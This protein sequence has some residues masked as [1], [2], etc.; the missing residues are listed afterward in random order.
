MISAGIHPHFQGP[1]LRPSPSTFKAFPLVIR[2][3]LLGAGLCEILTLSSRP[4]PSLFLSPP[5]TPPFFSLSLILS[6]LFRAKPSPGTVWMGSCLP[7]KPKNLSQAS[8]I[9]QNLNCCR[10]SRQ[11]VLLGAVGTR[12]TGEGPAWAGVGPWGLAGS[13]G[14]I[15]ARLEPAPRSGRHLALVSKGS[16]V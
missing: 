2:E 7:S 15:T 11:H 6:H 1:G 4:A 5:S 14:L 10:I 9:C 8:G 12:V 16:T 3:C 13:W